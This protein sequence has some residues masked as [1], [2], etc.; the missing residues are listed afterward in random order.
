VQIDGEVRVSVRIIL[1]IRDRVRSMVRV[2]VSDSIYVVWY[3]NR[4]D[5]ICKLSLFSFIS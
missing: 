4:G 5:P 1:R 3:K 2:R